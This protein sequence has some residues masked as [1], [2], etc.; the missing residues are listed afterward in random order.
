M[1]K[2]FAVL[3]ILLSLAPALLYADGMKHGKVTGIDRGGNSI[4]IDGKRYY[5]Y[6]GTMRHVQ[7]G[8]KVEYLIDNNYDDAKHHTVIIEIYSLD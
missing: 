4:E 2:I 8:D 3:I 1:K 6:K 7:K 5:C